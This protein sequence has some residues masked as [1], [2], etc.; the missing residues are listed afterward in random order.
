MEHHKGVELKP[1][2][3]PLKSTKM[4]EVCEDQWDASFIDGIGEI[5]QDL[6][7]LILAANYMDIKSLLHLGLAKVAS[8]IKGKPLDKLKEIL[9]TDGD[10]K[11]KEDQLRKKAA[12]K[13]DKAT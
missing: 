7:D 1:V 9:S 4:A 6:Y 12:E 8:L 10:S 2:E 5:R 13:K 11:R 3:S